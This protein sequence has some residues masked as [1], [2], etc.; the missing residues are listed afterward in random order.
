MILINKKKTTEE[1]ILQAKEIHGEK[2]NYS[3]ANY[4]NAK[5]NVIIICSIHGEFLQSPSNHLQGRGC[6]K[7]SYEIRAKN[8]I[9][10]I[11]NFTDKAKIVHKNFYNY[12][13]SEYIDSH[14]KMII[15][16]PIHGDFYQLP[17]H[18]LNGHG[19]Q[20]CN[21]K[22]RSGSGHHN[23]NPLLTEDERIFGR[24]ISHNNGFTYNNWRKSIYEKYNYSCDICLKSHCKIN[25]HH[26]DGYHWCKERRFDITNGVALCEDCHKE[27]HLIY[28]KKNNTES[29]YI[30]F[31]QKLSEFQ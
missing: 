12:D 31:R 3:K 23:Y 26:L 24:N 14:T 27:F 9:L 25:A 29:Q 10:G 17:T 21:L 8:N 7:C 6:E 4:I 11:E 16:C 30:E 19:C 20:D 22:R 13:S 18:H 1:F 28:G 5:E 2:Y 15:T